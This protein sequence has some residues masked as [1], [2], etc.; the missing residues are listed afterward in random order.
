[1]DHPL[2]ESLSADTDPFRFSRTGRRWL[3]RLRLSSDSYGE[4]VEEDRSVFTY[5]PS[6]A[7]SPGNFPAGI[8]AYKTDTYNQFTLNFPNTFGGPN[9]EVVHITTPLDGSHVPLTFGIAAAAGGPDNA[10]HMQIY[11]DVAKYADYVNISSL[12]GGTNITLPAPGV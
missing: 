7:K 6:I 5:S 8:P 4:P 9:A 1:M 11:V 10:S 12:P 3:F 2:F